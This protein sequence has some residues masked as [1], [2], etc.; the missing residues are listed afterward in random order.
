MF[1]SLYLNNMKEKKQKEFIKNKF[2][3]KVSLEVVNDLLLN[4]TDSFK[5]KEKEIT[6]FFSD[7]R[8]FTNISEQLDSPQRLIDLLNAYL[9]P[10]TTIIINHKGTIDKFIGDAVMAYWNAPNKLKNHPDLSVQTAIKQIDTLQELNKTLQSEFGVSLKIGIGIHTGL[11]VVGEMGSKGRSDYTIIGD[12]VN[13]TSRIEGLTKYF[14]AKILISQDTKNMLEEAY[15]FKYVAS[16]VVKGKTSSI[17]LY[18]VLNSTDYKTYELIKNNYE[19]AI[20]NYKKRNF[21]LSLDL[22]YKVNQIQ[23]HVLND[24]YI[25]K[26]INIEKSKD[27]NESL[28]FHMDSK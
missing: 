23:K 20:L 10:M 17:D 14:G 13:L 26:I 22:F 5:A 25:E 6:I 21:K 1:I 15:N 27:T 18:E 11:A 28:D 4:N 7:I 16:V 2:S 9:E 19:E 3:K 24:M 12:N 8:G